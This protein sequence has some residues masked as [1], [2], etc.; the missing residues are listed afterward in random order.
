M[1]KCKRLSQIEFGE[2]VT[3]DSDYEGMKKEFDT[4]LMCCSFFVKKCEFK[5]FKSIR[6]SPKQSKRRNSDEK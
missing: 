2:E 5:L 3:T 6:V 1:S 4:N